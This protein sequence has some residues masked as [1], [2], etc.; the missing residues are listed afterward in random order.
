MA[1]RKLKTYFQQTYWHWL[2]TALAICVGIGFHYSGLGQ[3]L[4]AQ[5]R[6]VLLRLKGPSQ[7]DPEI[8]LVEID[9]PTLDAI[10]SWPLPRRYYTQI[11]TR[12][13]EART[14]PIII[15]SILPPSEFSDRSLTR[16][17]EEHG[18]VIIAQP[19]IPQLQNGSLEASAAAVGSVDMRRS[20]INPF[21][22]IE[23]IDTDQPSLGTSAFDYI[24]VN[25][26]PST[27][28]SSTLFSPQQ[29]WLLNWPL[30]NNDIP[31]YSLIELLETDRSLADL[32]DKIV[33]IG[34]TATD[35]DPIQTPFSTHPPASGVHREAVVLQN[36]LN[37]QAIHTLSPGVVSLLYTLVGLSVT[38]LLLLLQPKT[39]IRLLIGTTIIW[40]LVTTTGLASNLWIPSLGP[41]SLVW[42]IGGLTALVDLLLSK[43]RVEYKID[44]VWRTH[45]LALVSQTMTRKSGWQYSSET[46]PTLYKLSALDRAI[47]AQAVI[48]RSLYLGLVAA[49]MDGTIWFC[50]STAARWL[51]VKVGD[52]LIE[53]LVPDWLNSDQWQEHQRSLVR[54]THQLQDPRMSLGFATQQL[55]TYELQQQDRWFLLKMEPLLAVNTPDVLGVLV[56][57]ENIT[58][59]KKM[60]ARLLKTEIRRRQALSEQNKALDKAR[61]MAESATQMKSAFLA[62]MS[63]EIRTPMNA[64]VGMASLLLESSLNEEQRDFVETIQTSGNHLITII[65]EILD[66]S[67]LEAGVLELEEIDID[68]VALVESVTDLL[69]SQ[70]QSKN[71]E[72]VPWVKSVVP[73]HLEGDPTRL[74]QILTNLVSNAIKFTHM[75]GVTVSVD[76]EADTK[77]LVTLRFEVTDTGIGIAPAKQATLFQPFTQADAS[78]TRQYGG[79]GLGLAICKR[80]VELM[81]G[82]IGVSSREGEGSAFWFQVP[83]VKPLK[84]LDDT[85]GRELRQL[86]NQSHLLIVED[87]AQVRQALT[88]HLSTYGVVV[89]GVS[90]GLTGLTQ[91][92]DAATAGSPYQVVLI[93]SDIQGLPVE[94]LL[95]RMNQDPQLALTRSV[96]IIPL[97]Q[98]QRAKQ[99]VQRGL[100]NSYIFK[101]IKLSRLLQTLRSLLSNEKDRSLL[102][103]DRDLMPLNEAKP[104]PKQSAVRLRILLAEDNP[105]NQKVAVKLLNSL[106]HSVDVAANGYEVLDLLKRQPFDVILM[107]CQMPLLD[108]FEATKLIRQQELITG[109]RI[110]IIALT[111]NAMK[112]DQDQ[113]LAAGMDGFLPKPVRKSDL[114]QTLSKWIHHLSLTG[115]L[116]MPVAATPLSLD[117]TSLDS[118]SSGFVEPVVVSEVTSAAVPEEL[119]SLSPAQLNQVSGGDTEFERELLVLFLDNCHAQMEALKLALSVN[120]YEMVRQQAHKLKGSSAYIGA[121]LIRHLSSTLEAQASHR[122][123][124][125]GMEL[126]G[127]LDTAFQSVKAHIEAQ[128]LS[129]SSQT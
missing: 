111:A 17:F 63:H 26:N 57:I 1:T 56:V 126:M 10:G 124:E 20:P 109:A 23:V 33:V 71:L 123:L 42:S 112:E 102:I 115:D 19:P 8:V 72:L 35:Y 41:I 114:D 68:M 122:D 127:E 44:Y 24:Q 95:T 60:Q 28:A 99:L 129:S 45:H 107:D 6:L 5:L 54:A 73:Q 12:L 47:G 25:L 65:N 83:L 61:Q 117:S 31:S 22:L 70:A 3:P 85:M 104:K 18:Q 125:R 7:W 103:Q 82:A 46:E 52:S 105:V 21:A 55:P 118:T 80:L 69:A 106:G 87:F 30:L 50:N 97:A 74:S 113:C 75:G 66:F 58:K 78:T 67:K 128:Y 81:G 32:S 89:H 43:A 92:K 40:L 48:A 64:V 77:R 90:D 86:L 51:N 29:T 110:T 108:G 98:Q 93:D 59:Q 116:S 84:T 49:N 119:T 100:V 4:T 2:A 53:H 76:V 27:S 39:R 120:D 88:D 13:T 38:G 36:L 62:S 101:P 91:L 37:H 15:D 94:R 14:G 11:I 96:L 121:D 79:T 34:I 16:A 9:D